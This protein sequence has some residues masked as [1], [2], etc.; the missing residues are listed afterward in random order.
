MKVILHVDEAKKWKLALENAKNLL[1]YG[2][3]FGKEYVV[4][5]LANSAAV[6]SLTQAKAK[7]EGLFADMEDL[8]IQAV[9]FVACR[10]ALK[11]NAVLEGSLIPFVEVVPAGVAELADKQADGYAYVKP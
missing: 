2:E 11:A 4:E 9:A 5:I 8:A 10:N 7:E 6:T 1:Q 3:E